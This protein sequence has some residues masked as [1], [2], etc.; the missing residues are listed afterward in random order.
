MAELADAQDLGS[1]GGDPCGFDPHYPHQQAAPAGNARGRRQDKEDSDEHPLPARFPLGRRFE[2]LSGRRLGHPRTAAGP[3]YGTL[4]RTRRARSPTAGTA[5]S[6]ATPTTAGRRTWRCCASWGRTATASPPAG[7][8]STRRRTG[9]GTRR[10]IAYY[11]R[12]VDALLAAGI[13]PAVTLYHWELPQAAEDRGGWTVCGTAEA[14]ARYAGMM[15]RAS[16]GG[17]ASGTRSTSRSVPWASAMATAY[18][19]RGAS[20]T[21]RGSSACW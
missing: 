10:G 12:L 17:C 14:F 16:A 2:R 20:W 21:Q 6:P 1:C 19:R 18:T 9:A 15:P 4:S 11:E 3:R 8:A 7:R 5:T 13:E